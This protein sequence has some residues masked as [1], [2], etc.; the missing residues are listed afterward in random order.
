M[1]SF[2]NIM[3]SYARRLVLCFPLERK[4]GDGI[5]R[6]HNR[7]LCRQAEEIKR[8]PTKKRTGY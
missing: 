2:E 6:V 1:Q 4:S 3:F 8:G 7:V 5:A